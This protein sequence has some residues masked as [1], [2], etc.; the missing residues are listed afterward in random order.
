MENWSSELD[1]T[2][3]TGADRH[4]FVA[5][6]QVSEHGARKLVIEVAGSLQLRT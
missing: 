5:L 6:W 3:M 4:A 1:M 2:E